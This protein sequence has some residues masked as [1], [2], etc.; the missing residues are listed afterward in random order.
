MPTDSA[1][2][3]F[4]MAVKL[5]DAAARTTGLASGSEVVRLVG[6]GAAGLVHTADLVGQFP[7]QAGYVEPPSETMP[8]HAPDRDRRLNAGI[9]DIRRKFGFHAITSAAGAN[10]RAKEDEGLVDG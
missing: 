1:G 5:L 6:V 8:E 10:A 3:V 7:G 9:D 4:G 2:V